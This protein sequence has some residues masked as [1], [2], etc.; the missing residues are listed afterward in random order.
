MATIVFPAFMVEEQTPG[1]EVQFN[2]SIALKGGATK[3]RRL[4]KKEQCN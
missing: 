2:K 1:N 4:N 3:K